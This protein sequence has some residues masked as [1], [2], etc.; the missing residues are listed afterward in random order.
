VE[1]TTDPASAVEDTRFISAAC[2]YCAGLPEGT[3]PMSTVAAHS[4]WG[5]VEIAFSAK[6]F[7]WFFTGVVMNNR[8]D[9]K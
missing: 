9:A 4:R 6:L 2:R 7:L 8:K 3:P 5:L 1:G